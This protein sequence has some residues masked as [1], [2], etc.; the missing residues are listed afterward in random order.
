MVATLRTI[1]TYK[2][3]EMPKP[4]WRLWAC[5]WVPLS[6]YC[7]LTPYN[8]GGGGSVSDPDMPTGWSEIWGYISFHAGVITHHFRY[9]PISVLHYELRDLGEDIYNPVLFCIIGPMA[10]G[11]CL[12]LIVMGIWNQI[13]RRV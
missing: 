5:I 12:H 7:L 4:N 3:F 9:H 10:A 11:Y 8:E 1:L 6:L 13:Q 2:L